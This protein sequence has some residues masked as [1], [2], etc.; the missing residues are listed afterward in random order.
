MRF[1]FGIR[2]KLL[3]I[4]RRFFVWI[5]IPLCFFASGFIIDM[6]NR[7]FLGIFDFRFFFPINRSTSSS[8]L[9]E[10]TRQHGGHDP[11]V[12]LHLPRGQ[13]TAM[14]FVINITN[15]RRHD[16][17]PKA[18]HGVHIGRLF[19][20]QKVCWVGEDISGCFSWVLICFGGLG[21][22]VEK[23]DSRSLHL[24]LLLL[25]GPVLG[26]MFHWVSMSFF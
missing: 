18:H 24:R 14:R 26:G 5:F 3:H 2:V 7:F 1:P 25:P 10:W 9:A 11:M 21:H 13:K 20:V 4:H 17:L 12:S 6:A 23:L 16:W 19:S 8:P 22:E 15:I